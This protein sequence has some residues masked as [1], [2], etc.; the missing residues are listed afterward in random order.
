MYR[1]VQKSAHPFSR[2]LKRS[3]EKK[4]NWIGFTDSSYQRIADDFNAR[5]PSRTSIF[6][7]YSEQ[8][9]K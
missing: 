9:D 5:N 3:K 8:G 1:V 4:R 6:F 7:R 2:R